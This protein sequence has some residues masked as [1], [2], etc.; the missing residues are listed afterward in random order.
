MSLFSNL[1]DLSV[2]VVIGTGYVTNYLA[3][4]LT[5]TK[6]GVNVEIFMSSILAL[7]FLAIPMIEHVLS[8]IS[9]HGYGLKTFVRWFVYFCMSGI[10][11]LM[12]R[13]FTSS[14]G[15]SWHTQFENLT[16]FVVLGL[17]LY[18]FYMMFRNGY[19]AFRTFFILD[20]DLSKQK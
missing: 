13:F 4:T 9:D 3:G 18:V 17:L 19:K 8:F 6:I 10:L 11:T 15:L 20:W 5:D 14:P 16:I 1:N 12:I 2:V 7:I